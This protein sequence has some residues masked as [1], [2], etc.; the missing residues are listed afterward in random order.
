MLLCS[1]F[2]LSPRCWK[3]EQRGRYRSTRGSSRGA[4]FESSL[5]WEAAFRRL[6]SESTPAI[7]R[8]FDHV[9]PVQPFKDALS[10]PLRALQTNPLSTNLPLGTLGRPRTSKE[11]T[12]RRLTPPR[13]RHLETMTLR[14]RHYTRAHCLLRPLEGKPPA[15]ARWATIPKNNTLFISPDLPEKISG[16]VRGATDRPVK[17]IDG[18][19]T[20]EPQTRGKGT[21]GVARGAPVVVK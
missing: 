15:A 11:T 5:P 14:L 8:R 16:G 2:S 18:Q 3:L 19:R 9:V 7:E 6:A 17:Y 4:I 21:E 20:A 10:M 1:R 13:K 12:G